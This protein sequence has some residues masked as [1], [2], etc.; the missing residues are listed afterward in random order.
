MAD[1]L[2]RHKVVRIG[3]GETFEAALDLTRRSGDVWRPE[4]LRKDGQPPMNRGSDGQILGTQS[5]QKTLGH[6]A[7][8]DEAREA[9]ASVL[10]QEIDIHRQWIAEDEAKLLALYREEPGKESTDD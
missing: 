2:P 5:W 1:P 6:Y 3:D 8:Y 7:L 10:R 9:K 4:N